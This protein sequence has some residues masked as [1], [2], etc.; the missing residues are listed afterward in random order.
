M[1]VPKYWCLITGCFPNTSALYIFIIPPVTF[2]QEA[3]PLI[4]HK[5]GEDSL[6]GTPFFTSI[7]NLMQLMYIYS[8]AYLSIR[9]V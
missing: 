2:Y 6:K 8:S 5:T 9:D 4:L 3:A 7:M 1:M